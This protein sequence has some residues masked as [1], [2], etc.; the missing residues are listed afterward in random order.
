MG[1]FESTFFPGKERAFEEIS[2][3]VADSYRANFSVIFSGDKIYLQNTAT[4]TDGNG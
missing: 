1:S 2:R 4:H 3:G